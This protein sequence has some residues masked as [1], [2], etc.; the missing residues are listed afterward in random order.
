MHDIAKLIFMII[1]LCVGM[2]SDL[3]VSEETSEAEKRAQIFDDTPVRTTTPGPTPTPGYK[4]FQNQGLGKMDMLGEVD[5]HLSSITNTL[6]Q[7]TERITKIEEAMKKIPQELEQIKNV[8]LPTIKKQLSTSIYGS[9]LSPN[10]AT[11][12][13][14]LEGIGDGE[15]KGMKVKVEEMY[16]TSVPNLQFEVSLLKDTVRTLEAM[17]TSMDSLKVK[18]QGGLSIE[19]DKKK[20]P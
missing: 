6:S 17:V 11:L 10:G 13:K 18:G 20:A 19:Q 2:L 14:V 1:V 12:G 4:S 16:V 9:S 7:L 5:K 3:C 15:L 8:E